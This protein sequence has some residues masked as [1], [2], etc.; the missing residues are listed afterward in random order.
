M[1]QEIEF[2]M[3]AIDT[4]I[5]GWKKI[6]KSCYVFITLKYLVAALIFS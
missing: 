5:A 3:S 1:L 2:V 6:R 4:G